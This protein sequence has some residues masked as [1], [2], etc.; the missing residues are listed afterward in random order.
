MDVPIARRRQP[1]GDAGRGGRRHVCHQR[2]RMLRARRRLRPVDLALSAPPHAQ[3]SGGTAAGGV[4]RGVAVAGDRVFMVTDNAHL[5]AL[6][7]FTGALLWDTEMADW[8]QNYYATIGAAVAGGP[9]DRRDRR[10]A[11]K[12]CA[13]SSRRSIRRPGK[14]V[15][16]FWTVPAA[17]RAGL[18]DLE[19]QGHRAS[20]AA[21]RGSPAPTIPQLD[22]VYWPT[23][24]PGARLQRRRPRRRQSLLR[25]ASWRWMRRPAS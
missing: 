25:L 8:R 24:N 21:P 17:R 9:G 12:A 19:G 23:G 3:A 20:A 14:E 2:Q 10:A 6:D 15:W 11:T 5:I 7:R 4:N 22:T 18:G 13:A 16:R 1:A